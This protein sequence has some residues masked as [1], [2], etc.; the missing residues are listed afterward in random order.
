[1]NKRKKF[2]KFA[3]R[4]LILLIVIILSVALV[5]ILNSKKDINN[6]ENHRLIIGSKYID[7]KHDIYVD[8]L[9]NIY[10]SKQDIHDL[11]DSNIYYDSVDNILITTFNKHIAKLELDNK[12]IEINGSKIES[13]ATLIKLEEEIYLP[14]SEMGIVYDF[15]YFYSKDTKTVIVDSISE[16]KNEATLIKNKAKIKEEPK[17]FSS[18]VDEISKDEKVVIL[19]DINNYFKVR[20]E[21]GNV[22]YIK[23]SKLSDIN[24]IRENMDSTRIEELVFLDYNDISKDYSDMEINNKKQNAVNI[25]V[26]TIKNEQLISNIDT[27]SKDYISYKEWAEENNI[28]IIAE[29]NCEDEVIDDFLTYSQ[30]NSMIENIYIKLVQNNLTSLNI[31]FNKINDVNSYYRFL[32]E[33]APILRESGIKI[34]VTNNEVLNI[35]KLESIVDYIIK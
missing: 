28:M 18:K 29:L 9:D 19:E 20:T 1:M 26:F 23:K 17:I 27:K 32:I 12:V 30:R 6:Y 35:E 7:L 14:F 10:L 3:K 24:K 13:N 4:R 34:I 5:V 11:Y 22:G 15:E 21:R 2:D 16:E 31:N 33:L 25:N 8:S